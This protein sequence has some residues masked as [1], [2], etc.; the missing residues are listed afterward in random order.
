MLTS[1]DS[2]TRF[3][4]QISRPIFTAVW[5][6]YVLNPYFL[7]F[8]RQAWFSPGRYQ[9]ETNLHNTASLSYS[10]L[11]GVHA[12]G[13]FPTPQG[14]QGHWRYWRNRTF[15]ISFSL[16]C[17]WFLNWRTGGKGG[18]ERPARRQSWLCSESDRLGGEGSQYVFVF[19]QHKDR[20]ALG[21]TLFSFE[22]E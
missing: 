4:K 19:H 13:L 7:L 18:G 3:I 2:E 21:N 6:T 5:S 9:H 17:S 15:H 14:L 16:V 8:E 11:Q 12:S 20:M 22:F 1:H 10:V